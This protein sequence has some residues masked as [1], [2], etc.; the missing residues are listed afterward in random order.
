MGHRLQFW[1]TTVA[2]PHRAAAMAAHFEAQGWDG[3]LVVDSQ[4][5]AGDPYV[6][7]AMAATGS[8]RLGLGTGVTNPV[9]RHAAATATAI[10]GVHR[11]SGGRA[12][13]GIGRGDSALA[14]LGHSPARVAW[15]ERYL[16]NLQSYLGGDEV[17]FADSGIPAEVAPP[18]DD[19]GLAEAPSASRIE[20]INPD[21]KVPVEVAA[22]GPRV[23]AAAARH[24]ERVMFALGAEP[25]RVAWGIETA[26]AVAADAGRELGDLDLGAYV[27]VVPHPDVTTARRLAS[28]GTSLFARFS[29][30]DGE[31]RGPADADQRAVLRDIHDRYDMTMHARPGGAQTGALTDEFIDR[32][33]IVGDAEH[34][35]SRLEELVQ[36]GITRVAVNGVG[37]GATG[38][39]A[40]AA[41]LLEREVMPRFG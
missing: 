11:L 40:E 26:R 27:T 7:L 19:L 18:L 14:H 20:W 22:T 9:T 29:V 15:F 41:E 35:V 2:I 25:A 33:A 37:L 31:I 23:I 24:A 17:S 16:A 36:L 3:M 30:M 4:N 13:L 38:P 5:L 34:C 12:V 6:T 32:F 21:H 1:T 39:A 8:S 10:A 28:T